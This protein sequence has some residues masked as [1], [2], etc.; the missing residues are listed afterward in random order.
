MRPLFKVFINMT[1]YARHQ[2]CKLMG[3]HTAKVI[4]GESACIKF[5]KHY[6]ESLMI[7]Y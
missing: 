3:S 2:N 6:T 5:L 7:V 1:T 4:Y